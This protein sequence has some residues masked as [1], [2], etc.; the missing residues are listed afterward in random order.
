V[1][2]NVVFGVSAIILLAVAARRLKRQHP[3]T[4]ITRSR[5][6]AAPAEAAQRERR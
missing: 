2:G 5:P 1:L 6:Q 3:S 4:A